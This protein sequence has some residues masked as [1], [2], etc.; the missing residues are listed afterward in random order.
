MNFF[1][2]RLLS[3]RF[4]SFNCWDQKL[5]LVNA[6]TP[7][8][9]TGIKESVTVVEMSVPFL[10][11]HLFLVNTRIETFHCLLNKNEKK[12]KCVRNT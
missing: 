12:K 2:K 8:N 7:F 10:Q 1:L 3:R 5:M 4:S 9:D 11:I 6:N